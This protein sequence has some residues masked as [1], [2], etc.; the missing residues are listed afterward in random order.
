[1][2]R[3]L[4][5]ALIIAIAGCIEDS[6]LPQGI[7]IDN[8]TITHN[9]TYI[10]ATTITGIG[11]SANSGN[12]TPLISEMN[13]GYWEGNESNPDPFFVYVYFSNVS[14]FDLVESVHKYNSSSG[15]P[16]SHIVQ[17]LIWCTI[18]ND[19]VELEEF[20]NQ[21]LWYY[22]VKDIPDTSHFIYPNG[23]VII[24]YQH[25]SNGNSA[26]RIFIDV[27][28]LVSKENEVIQ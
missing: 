24:K 14:H 18:H 28:R 7:H 25:L 10:N 12:N 6:A 20:S 4:I 2:K 13:A 11:F 8:D 5:L 15:T 17:R 19:W 23:T 22:H 16:S 21:E 9:R 27:C 1:M 3:L 26:H